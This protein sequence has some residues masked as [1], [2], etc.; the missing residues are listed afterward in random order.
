MY[1]LSFVANVCV[2][3]ASK[4]FSTNMTTLV[5]MSLII[6]LAVALA[7]GVMAMKFAKRSLLDAA[8]RDGI[9]RKLMVDDFR[10]P[11]RAWE[12][13]RLSPG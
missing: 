13:P 11:T 4:W 5:K 1:T 9:R 12:S 7:Y 6:P 10:S 3:D 8:M 2:E